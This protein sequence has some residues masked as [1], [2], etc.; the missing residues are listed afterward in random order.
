MLTTMAETLSTSCNSSKPETMHEVAEVYCEVCEMWLNGPTQWEDHQIG[1]K[2][3]TRLNALAKAG[4]SKGLETHTEE[5]GVR[6]I[7]ASTARFIPSS[8]PNGYVIIK[9]YSMGG[10]SIGEVVI[11]G[12]NKW[13]E[14]AVAANLKF[15]EYRAIPPKNARSSVASQM[16]GGIILILRIETFSRKGLSSKL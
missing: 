16:T 4:E 1:K 9:C 12:M 14:I 11:P 7:K 13:Q 6:S 3:K 5:D 8:I 10:D 2:H 15:P